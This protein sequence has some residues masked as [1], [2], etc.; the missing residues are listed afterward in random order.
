MQ[1]N[2]CKQAWN[3]CILKRNSAMKRDRHNL[4]DEHRPEK[5]RARIEGEKKHS[6]LADAVLGGID[7]GVT[8]FA[9]VAG[10]QGASLPGYVAIVLGLANLL[11]DGFSMAV[12][13]YQSTK[14]E[15]EEIDNARG[16]EQKHIE[17][18]PKAERQELR[19]IFR[20]KGIRGGDLDALVAIFSRH[21]R[22]WVD[23][24]VTEEL[25]LL[26]RKASPLRAAYWTL[27]AFMVIGFIP[28]IPYLGASVL[29]DQT[30]LVSA[31]ITAL[32][33]AFV[34]AAKGYVLERNIWRAGA[35]T[36]LT[37]GGAAALAYLAAWSMRQLFGI[38]G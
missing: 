33:F 18:I 30:F 15:G 10:V 16:S 21:P 7:G 31:V 13:N 6:W 17:Q 11:A 8:T 20:K 5:I 23:M 28:L 22:A 14:A 4:Q 1:K 19:M 32:T 36:L 9:V 24:M 12:S 38:S 35:E 3:V 37:G 29:G 26:T 27:L 34:G 25:G 2:A